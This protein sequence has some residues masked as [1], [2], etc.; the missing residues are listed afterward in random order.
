MGIAQI[1]IEILVTYLFLH[2]A[3]IYPLHKSVG[4]KGVT[5]LVHLYDVFYT[6]SFSCLPED[7]AYVV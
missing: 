7:C 3:R 2:S 6:R 5:E 1:G 4:A